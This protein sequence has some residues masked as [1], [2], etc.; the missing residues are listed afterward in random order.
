MQMMNLFGWGLALG[1]LFFG[2]L[3]VNAKRDFFLLMGLVCCVLGDFA[4]IMFLVEQ[5]L[6]ND[7]VITAFA[8]LVAFAAYAIY[9]Q[10]NRYRDEG[11]NDS[12]DESESEDESGDER[13]D[14][15]GGTGGKGKGQ[16]RRRIDNDGSSASTG[17]SAGTTTGATTTA[18][19][20][21][22]NSGGVR[23]RR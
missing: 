6:D 23:H 12:D 9:C 5:E 1:T 21:G 15:D 16:D 3:G 11:C 18:G 14:G 19:G 22:G 10:F 4:F 7:T 20:G 8:V 13:G 2:F 17:T